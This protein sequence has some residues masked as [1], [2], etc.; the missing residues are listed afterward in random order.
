MIISILNGS[1]RDPAWIISITSKRFL[2][3]NGK[4]IF[5]C[6]SQVWHLPK[7]LY[8][9]SENI[10]YRVFLYLTDNVL[11][12]KLR[13]FNGSKVVYTTYNKESPWVVL[14]CSADSKWEWVKKKRLA[15][16]HLT[17]RNGKGIELWTKYH[18]V[19]K[20]PSRYEYSIQGIVVW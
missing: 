9:L 16:S 19:E 6:F 4:R 1:Y 3:S 17:I 20:W 7:K 18:W 11:V 15:D 13:N 12:L 8:A 14:I 2:R 5:R 10:N